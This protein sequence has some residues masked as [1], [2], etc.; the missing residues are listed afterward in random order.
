[1]PS[2]FSNLDLICWSDE[3]GELMAKKKLWQSRGNA[4]VANDCNLDFFFSSCN[5]CKNKKESGS[6]AFLFGGPRYTAWCWRLSFAGEMVVFPTNRTR[7]VKF[8][9]CELFSSEKRTV[10]VSLTRLS[11]SSCSTLTTLLT[12]RGKDFWASHLTWQRHWSKY[13][14]APFQLSVGLLLMLMSFVDILSRTVLLSALTTTDSQTLH[15]DCIH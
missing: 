10:P 14:L 1:M 6:S 2:R 9:A 12:V 11:P 15:T 7:L 13:F 3:G 4:E 8:Y 5:D